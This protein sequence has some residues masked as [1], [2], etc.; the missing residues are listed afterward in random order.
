MSKNKTPIVAL[1]GR[2]NVGK[3]SLY[4]AFLGRREAIVAKEPG[5]TRDSLI[6]KVIWKNQEFFIVDTAGA[7]DP[8]DDFEFTIQEQISQATENADLILLLTEANVPIND[9]DR[10]LSNQ[11]LKS[12][13]NVLLVINKIDQ[14]KNINDINH[15]N[16]VGI[17]EDIYISVTQNRGIENLLNKIVQNLP[18]IKPKKE[19]Q[20]KIKVSIVGRPNVGKSN[21]FNGLLKKQQ[22][23]VSDR[24][25]TTRDINRH[26]IKYNSLNIEF[27]DTAGI[28]RS[29][30]I[31]VGVEKFSVLR[32][33]KAIEESDVCL[34]LIDVNELNVQL[35]QKIAGMIKD[36]GKGII[37][38]V[39]KWD[40]ATDKDP[41][42]RD[43]IAHQ[44]KYSFDFVS[45]SPMIF[46][47]SVTGQNLTKLFDLIIE[48]TN[49][50]KQKIPTSQLNNWLSG[51]ITEHPPSG[52]KNRSPKLNYIIQEKDN[53]VP[54]FKIYGSN[55]KFV[56]WSYKRY[57]ENR[58]RQK[59]GFEGCT[60][61]IW[62]I[63]KHIAHK[64]GE[65]PKY[66]KTISDLD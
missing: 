32:T 8:D 31:E 39:S 61:Q 10:K 64:H 21:L 35:D 15:I 45:Y 44:I 17:K 58:L 16:Q 62:F 52:T 48:V 7:K 56:H 43:K 2:A 66:T 6:S 40:I 22:A 14:V 47:S 1:V 50:R 33:I 25:G 38:V 12:K 27:L 26:S 3:S 13:K 46:T 57:L 53:D 65:S 23:I 28:R 59:F 11:A 42:L 18:K 54:A 34:L 9:I 19:D 51:A 5:T 4:N 63:E 37:I 41:Y 20:E 24:A 60:I 30:K 55:T 49:N 36:A 29:G